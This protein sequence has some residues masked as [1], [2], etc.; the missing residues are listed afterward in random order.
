ML[1]INFLLLG[2]FLRT[3]SID[4]IT[5][6]F[7]K[8]H[9][10]SDQKY[11]IISLGA[12]F[13]TRLFRFV[14]EFENKL[15]GLTYFEIDFDQVIREKR[16]LVEMKPILKELSSAWRPISFD[17]NEGISEEIFGND[18]DPSFPTLIIAECCFMY[19]TAEAGDKIISW[20]GNTFKSSVTLCSFDPILADDIKADPF[21]KV[22]LDNFDKRGLDTRALLEYP[23][24]QSTIDRFKKHFPVVNS[25][26]MLQLETTESLVSKQQRREVLI[27][28]ALDE[29][30]EWNLLADHYLLIIAQKN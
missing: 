7:L 26:T 30:E 10:V 20:C 16:R 13:D 25:F 1:T 3:V 14:N 24:R 8:L 9:S 6:D 27:K 4:S 5:R 2:T 23:S 11:Q 18:F 17:L 29:Y 12:G 21:A 28:A 19:L 15:E 22:M